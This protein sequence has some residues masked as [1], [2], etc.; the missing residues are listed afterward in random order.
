ML[1]KSELGPPVPVLT[2][3]GVGG[4]VGTLLVELG[5]ISRGIL[6]AMTNFKLISHAF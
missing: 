6:T 3:V 1:A 5:L 4:C 2:L